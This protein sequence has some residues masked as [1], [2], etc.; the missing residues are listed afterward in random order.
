MTT[1]LQLTLACGDYDRTRPLMDG[2]VKPEGIDLIFLSLPGEETFWRMIRFKEF[3]VSEMSLSSYLLTRSRGNN[4]FIAIPVFVSR[5]FRHSSIYI[6]AGAGIKRPLDLIGKRVGVPEYQVTAAVWARGILQHEYGVSPEQ[7]E[8]KTGGLEQ[9]GR[10]EK[11]PLSLPPSVRLSSIPEE[12]TLS[13]MLEM[14]ELD[15][16]IS[17]RTPSSY[18]GGKE[19]VKRLF[20][21]YR[22][23]ET[24][25]YLRTRIFPIMH[26]VVIRSDIYNSHPWV[27]QSLYKAFSLARD[28]CCQHLANPMKFSLPWLE[29]EV[30]AIK[31]IL[32]EDLWPYGLEANEDVL[33]TFI[34]Y[35]AE[36][37]LIEKRIEA[38]ALFAEN[39]LVDYRI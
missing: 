12:K 8:W 18:K 26:T 36:Q 27:A 29:C 4:D 38:K 6:H 11:I 32:G 16:L 2:T 3:H 31:G 10:E 28:I 37:G 24:E 14:G 39:T 22:R 17:P 35:S 15:A 33:K 30:E 34:H 19:R 1:R 9:P 7:M 13:K 20:E 23:E 5:R 25:Y 21:D